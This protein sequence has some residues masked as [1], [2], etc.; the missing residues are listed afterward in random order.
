MKLVPSGWR[1]YHARGSEQELRRLKRSVRA[2]SRRHG[3]TT[4]PR[5][6]AR[7][8]MVL[9]PAAILLGALGWQVAASPWP[10]LVAVKHLLAAPNCDAARA[11]G[12][13]PA[14][15]GAPGYYPSHDRDRDGISCEPWPRAG[16]EELVGRPSVIDGDTLEI[17]GQRVR[18]HGIDALETAQPCTQGG[19]SVRCGQQAALALAARIGQAPVACE[20]KDR[21][22]YGRI[23]AICRLGGEDLNRWMVASGWA[24]AYREYSDIYVAAERTAARAG[25]GIRA[26][27]FTPPW[28]WRRT[29]QGGA[30]PRS[31]PA[32]M[33]SPLAVTK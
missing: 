33:R 27:K 24:M 23:V 20:P 2:I 26:T 21:D 6:V 11:A 14:N 12:L 7:W 4:R 3:R 29:K 18:L 9:A 25:L 17:R 13:A 10:P 31:M 1:V 5:R 32:P 28:D 16:A 8:A 22:R 19:A 30:V 15:R